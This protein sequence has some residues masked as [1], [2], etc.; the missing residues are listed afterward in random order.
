MKANR[1]AIA[2]LAVIV[3]AGLGA[4]L[5]WGPPGT[6]ANTPQPLRIGVVNASEASTALFVADEHGFF[7]GNGLNVTI[8]PYT[9]GDQAI[10]AA[11]AGEVEVAMATEYPLVVAALGDRA[12]SVIGCIDRAETTSVI[13]RSDRG[14]ATVA[15]LRGKRVGVTRR[16]IPEFYLGRLLELNGMS[17]SDVTVVD[18]PRPQLQDAI[19]NGSVDAV[20]IGKRE[21]A[22]IM[23]R[24]GGN[25]VAFSANSGQPSSVLLVCDSE[26]L[27][28]H[29]H[30]AERL[31]RAL[32]V[33]DEYI[34]A[35]PADAR[36]IAGRRAN[37]SEETVAAVW[38]NHRFSLS[39]DRSLL[40]AMGDEAHWMI[41]NNL[42]SAR[43]PPDLRAYIDTTALARVKPDAVSI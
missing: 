38:P 33:A 13:G 17:L 20:V 43:T 5:L 11:E 34:L 40:T 25:A 12:V 24:F 9:D 21:V 35:H 32:A 42:T 30:D 37:L 1:I 26:W 2:A 29:P 18:V 6:P 31:L 10:A 14:V 8:R 4:A 22:P 28:A 41:A 36:A 27:A 15:D 7:A 3:L 39:L 19:I 23:A 16:T